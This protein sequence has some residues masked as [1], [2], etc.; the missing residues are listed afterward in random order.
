MPFFFCF[1]NILQSVC[2][3]SQSKQNRDF[4]A[5]QWLGLHA[6]TAK[7]PGLIPGRGTMIPLSHVV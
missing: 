7:D 5:V 2:V 6:F 1:S 3:I 4:L